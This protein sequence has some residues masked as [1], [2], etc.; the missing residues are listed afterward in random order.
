MMQSDPTIRQDTSFVHYR[1]HFSWIKHGIITALGIWILFFAATRTHA[2]DQEVPVKEVINTIKNMNFSTLTLGV[3][4]NGLSQSTIDQLTA[5]QTELPRHMKIFVTQSKAARDVFVDFTFLVNEKE[6][7]TILIW[8][9]EDLQTQRVIKKICHMSRM[10]KV[11]IIAL[12]DSW[13]EEGA[14]VYIKTEGSDIT[15]ME[16]SVVTKAMKFTIMEKPNYDIV[17]K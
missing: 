8:P 11:P 14:A 16:N 4:S 2:A 15:V 3:I 9:S 6:V 7:D 10:K 13:L 1:R 12:N 17:Q 5:L